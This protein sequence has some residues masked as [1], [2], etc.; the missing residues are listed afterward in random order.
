MSTRFSRFASL[1]LVVRV[2]LQALLGG[3][4]ATAAFFG[5]GWF[6]RRYDPPERWVSIGCVLFVSL[7][8]FGYVLV[9]RWR[10]H[11]HDR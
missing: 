10:Y 11:R 7:W 3:L 4:I 5:S 6:I 1:P 8:F 9:H 2:V